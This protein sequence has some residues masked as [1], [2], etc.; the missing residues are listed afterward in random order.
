MKRLNLLILAVLFKKRKTT[1][2]LLYNNQI[3]CIECNKTMTSIKEIPLLI[4][5]QTYRYL[6]REM[7][8]P[9]RFYIA[10]RAVKINGN[11]IKAAQNRNQIYHNQ[12]TK[13]LNFTKR[14]YRKYS[15]LIIKTNLKYWTV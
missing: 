7:I 8:L 14:H 1:N 11:P 15:Q 2:F 9:K 10:E 6:K 3:F 12:K 13:R 4:T 5:H